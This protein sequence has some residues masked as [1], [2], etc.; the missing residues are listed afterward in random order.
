M[1]TTKPNLVKMI[2]QLAMATLV[3]SLFSCSEDVELDDVSAN[4][5]NGQNS[6]L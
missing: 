1:K 6:V 4:A 2:S 3:V 5:K